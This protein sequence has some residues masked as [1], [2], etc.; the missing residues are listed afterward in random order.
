MFSPFTL[1]LKEWLMFVRFAWRTWKMVVRRLF[2][3]W[4]L[5]SPKKSVP[6]MCR[7]DEDIAFYHEDTPWKINME[8]NS[9]EV[10]F[11]SFSFL[12]GWF[13]G[14][15]LIFQG[16]SKRCAF[17][18]NEH[19]DSVSLEV[20]LRFVHWKMN[21]LW[22]DRVDTTAGRSLV[23]STPLYL[24]GWQNVPEKSNWR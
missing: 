19:L 16:V 15:M 2:L 23:V 8:H 22:A 12:N 24:M 4:D 10:W 9:L 1:R 18:W 17:L 14:S 6:Q 5:G 21:F 7:Y 13:V 20:L 3:G 11:R